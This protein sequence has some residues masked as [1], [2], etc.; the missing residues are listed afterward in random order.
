M[1]W[2]GGV[3]REWEEGLGVCDL[4]AVAGGC[5]LKWCT[6]HDCK[7][8]LVVFGERWNIESFGIFFYCLRLI[9]PLWKSNVSHPP[10]YNPHFF[11]SS[12]PLGP[13]RKLLSNENGLSCL[14]LYIREV[15]RHLVHWCITPTA[16]YED[17][18][19]GS[20]AL[21]RRLAS[22]DFFAVD[23]FEVDLTRLDRYVVSGMFPPV[24]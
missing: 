1:G 13:S 5:D 4:G 6:S 19:I 16:E 10:S 12:P 8:I 3:D 2:L 9:V 15:V 22:L 17:R 21:A 18:R 23:A 14:V 7:R 20:L 11:F 24:T